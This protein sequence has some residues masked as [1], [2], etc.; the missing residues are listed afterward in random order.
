MECNARSK[1]RL[2]DWSEAATPLRKADLNVLC[3]RHPV[4]VINAAILALAA[5]I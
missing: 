5:G 1:A 2:L 4:N 3:T